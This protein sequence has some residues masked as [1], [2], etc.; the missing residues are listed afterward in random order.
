MRCAVLGVVVDVDVEVAL[1]KPL[2]PCCCSIGFPQRQME[3]LLPLGTCWGKK[4]I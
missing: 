2:P 4:D 1:P 3:K